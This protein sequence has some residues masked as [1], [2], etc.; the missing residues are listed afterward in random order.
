M[1]PRVCF[2][3]GSKCHQVG[4]QDEL[5]YWIRLSGD[6]MAPG[7]TNYFYVLKSSGKPSFREL[8]LNVVSI[9][10]DKWAEP[11]HEGKSALINQ[12]YER[13][14]SHTSSQTKVLIK[15]MRYLFTVIKTVKSLFQ[16]LAPV[17]TMTMEWS[18]SLCPHAVCLQSWKDYL[19]SIWQ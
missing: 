13:V 17:F 10:L 19:K 14:C 7:A 9:L 4:N 1:C 5:L 16:I 6:F 12:I 11:I 18:L 8:N 3:G 15:I 2:H